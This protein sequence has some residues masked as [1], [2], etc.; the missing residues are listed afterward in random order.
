[1][2]IL[3]EL[4]STPEIIKTELEYTAI[5]YSWFRN[6]YFNKPATSLES[7]RSKQVILVYRGE[8]ERNNIYYGVCTDCG[9]IGKLEWRS[10]C[11][12][13]ECER[14][15]CCLKKICSEHC[16]VYCNNGHLNQYHND[17]GEAQ[18]FDCVICNDIIKPTYSWW[19]LSIKEHIAKYD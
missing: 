7:L 1:M 17:D 6:K 12:D 2:D 15:D 9:R 8:Y 18:P 11:A 4:D 3:P 19:G 10:A 16:Q 14:V 13:T 5:Y